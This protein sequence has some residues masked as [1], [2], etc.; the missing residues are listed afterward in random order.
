[1]VHNHC[2]LMSLDSIGP[3]EMLVSQQCLCMG[4]GVKS[5]DHNYTNSRRMDRLTP[6]LDCL[7]PLHMPFPEVLRVPEEHRDPDHWKPC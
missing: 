1:M 2:S 6:F 3:K 4:N 7:N 5:Q